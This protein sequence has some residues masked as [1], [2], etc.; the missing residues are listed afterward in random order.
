MFIKAIEFYSGIGGMGLA[1]E[2]SNVDGV[3]VRAIDVDQSACQ[4]YAANH[5]GVV[6]KVDI[7]TLAPD[8][9]LIEDAD[10]WLL[11]PPCQPYT[12]LSS[13]KDSLDPRAQSFLHLI[14]N[15]LPGLVAREAHPRYLIVENVA[16]FETS[17]TRQL[18]RDTLT[19]LNYSLFECLLTPLHFG[20]PNS[21]LRYYL[22]AKMSFNSQG[23]PLSKNLENDKVWRCLPTREPDADW[24]DNFTEPMM[25]PIE[26][27]LDAKLSAEEALVPERV[28]AKW[29]RLFDI[30]LPSSQ[31]TCCFTRGYTQLVERTGSI[32]QMNEHL[33]TKTVFDEFLQA[34]SEGD[35]TAVQILKQLELRYFTPTELLRLF[36]FL[37][38]QQP[39]NERPFVWPHGI[40]NRTKYRLIGNSVNVNVV[41]RLINFLFRA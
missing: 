4:V 9:S 26:P 31:R 1:L 21:R 3:V 33:D 2:R 28:L 32:L 14:R 15:V 13:Q 11:S 37:S 25:T 29:G 40:S 30:V 24:P 39:V 12:V 38:L 8:S 27:Y 22:L 18:L 20:I 7:A 10:L 23:F 34:Q 19:A 17:N 41:T 36:G 16:A 35:E 5:P 6:T